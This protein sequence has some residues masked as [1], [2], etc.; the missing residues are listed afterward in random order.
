M[1]PAHK[2]VEMRIAEDAAKFEWSNQL[3]K[4]GMRPRDN[5]P[6]DL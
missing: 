4:Y 6:F 5:W 1:F 2:T 3:P